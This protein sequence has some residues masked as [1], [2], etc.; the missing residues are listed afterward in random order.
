MGKR[1]IIADLITSSDL[2]SDV[3]VM[4][5][6]KTKRE[7]KGGFSFLEVNDGST[8][9]NIQVIADDQLPN[10]TQEVVKLTVGCSVIV[11]GTLVE[12]PGKGQ[13][14]EVHAKEVRVTGWADPDRYPLQ[15]KRHSF[16]YLRTI[17]HL[18]PRT[19]TFGAVARIRNA[20][21]CLLYTSPSPRDLSTSRMPSSA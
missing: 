9:K 16:E 17:A 3:T 2:G 8:I 7:S 11:K 12:S 20:M 5:W 19:N 1:H 14:V 4:G 15:K 18:R 21:S 6:V 10:Y 13:K